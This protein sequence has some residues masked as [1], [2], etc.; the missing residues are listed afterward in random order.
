MRSVSGKRGR[1]NQNT[2]LCSITPPR[3]PAHPPPP[4]GSRAVNEIMWK[5]IVDPGRPQ[6]AI[7]RMSFACRITKAA[8]T[9]SNMLILLLFHCISGY[10]KS[11]Q[12]N[13]YRY[14]HLVINLGCL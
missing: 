10:A 3:P 1:E 5:N 2:L 6:M 9:H 11:P 7:W 13:V 14:A 8:D 4:P 12:A